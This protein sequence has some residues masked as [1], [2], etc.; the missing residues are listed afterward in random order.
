MPTPSTNKVPLRTHEIVE[1]L[2]RLGLLELM[3]ESPWPDISDEGGDAF[4]VDWEDVERDLD[5]PRALDRSDQT[6]DRWA[7]VE[8]AIRARLR[9]D[10]GTP[11]PVIVDALAW[12]Q[13]IHYFGLAWGV[14]IKEEAVLEFAASLLEAAPPERRFDRDMIGGAVRLALGIL[15][16][17][18]AFHHRIESFAIGLEIVDHAK[19]Y[20]PYHDNVYKS[21]RAAGSSELIEEALATAESFRRR[22]EEPYARLVPGD[23]KYAAVPRLRAWI[24]ALPPG[25]NRAEQ[26]F[27]GGP[28][29][30]ALHRLC[31]QVDEARHLPLRPHQ[32]WR[33][34]ANLHRTLFNCKTVTWVVVPVGAHPIVPWFDNE[35]IAEL[36]ISTRSLI[37]A[38]RRCYGYEEHHGAKHLKLVREGGPVLILPANREALS[39]VVLT[40]T[41]H[42]LGFSS[43]RTMWAELRSST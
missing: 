9:P 27:A 11:P 43:A 33:L 14:Y 34:A 35:A 37:K 41:A 23:L 29:D 8:E 36:S 40:N 32:E 38:L 13:P 28:F 3:G 12:Y 6:A 2:D 1:T 25:Y 39:P 19:R 42:A 20:C 15:Y 18:E 7:R 26:F 24:R 21:L 31:S 17:H 5:N 4:P 30:D 10:G 22:T 16:L